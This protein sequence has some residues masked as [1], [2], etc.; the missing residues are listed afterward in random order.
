MTLEEFLGDMQS[1]IDRFH[2]YWRSQQAKEGEEI[3]PANMEPGDWYD[4][5]LGF[6]DSGTKEVA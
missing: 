3:F 6:I 4:Q 5:W 2:D 1:D